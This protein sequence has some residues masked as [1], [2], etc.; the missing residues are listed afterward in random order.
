M[1]KSQNTVKL[2]IQY[3]VVVPAGGVGQR[4]LKN[5]AHE[6][7]AIAKQYL[8]VHGKTILEH[9]V[10]GFLADTDCQHIYIAVTDSEIKTVSAMFTDSRVSIIR[11]GKT[12]MQSVLAGLNALHGLI[13]EDA[14]IMVHDA[15]RAN[16]YASDINKL[17]KTIQHEAYG[18]ILAT[19]ARDT[20]KLVAENSVTS[21]LPREK[22]WHALTPQM[23]RL[24]KLYSAMNQAVLEGFHLSDEA[25]ALEFIGAKV[26]LVAGRSDN[27]KLTYKEDLAVL[28]AL[29][30]ARMTSTSQE[31][32]Q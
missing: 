10:S 8:T 22:I 9:S 28:H 5:S 29:I 18:G 23:F 11:G 16:L 21:T 12:R 19:P 14:W 31:S 3:S 27:I 24:G 1:N 15:A 32:S 17:K 4:M 25:S 7:P 2:P 30:S 26:V 13:D 6:N 20:L